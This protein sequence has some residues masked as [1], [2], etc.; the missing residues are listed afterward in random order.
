MNAALWSFGLYLLGVFALAILAGRFRRGKGF[1]GEYFLGSRDLGMW[2]FAL[3][4]AATAASGGSFM[5]FPSLV[6]THG[7]SLALWIAGYMTVP[8]VMMGLLGKRLNQF[9]RRAGAVTAPEVLGARYATPWVGGVATAVLLFFLFFY[10]VAQFK[11]GSSILA[12]LLRDVPAYQSAAVSLKEWVTPFEWLSDTSA[13]YLLSLLIFAVSVGVYTT[14]G[15]FRAVVW[16]DVMQGAVMAVGVVVLLCLTLAATGGLGAMTRT[17]ATMTPPE[18]GE[19][20]LTVEPAA[21]ERLTVPSGTW[22]SVPKQDGSQE[23]VRTGR[24]AVIDMG[25]RASEPVALLRVT[26]DEEASRI[27]SDATWTDL[28]V[29][30]TS[31]SPYAHGAGSPGAYIY[32][33]GPHPD[34][35]AGFLGL[36]MAFSFFVFWAFAG[37]GQP[38]AMVR[39]MAFRDSG[40]LKRAIVLVALYFS[41]IYFALVMVFVGARVLLPGR[42]L[43][44]DRIMPELATYLTQWAGVPWLAGLVVAA[45]FAAVMSSVD[46]FLL[47]LSSGVVRDI[48]QK[49]IHP[50]APE[51]RI[52]KL[53]YVSTA[54]IACAAMVVAIRPPDYLQKLIVF[55]SGGLAV[56]FLAPV[57]GSIYWRRMSGAGAIAGMLAGSGA[58]LWLYWAG[59]RATGKFQALEFLGLHSFIW[60]FLVSAV[61]S[62]VVSVWGPKPDPVRTRLFFDD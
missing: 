21:S 18:L 24:I 7:W 1:V 22:L 38:S 3:T 40:T 52:R 49:R 29:E 51:A 60:A 55:S 54:L 56:S 50:A 11:A 57:M 16:T 43:E 30:W 17:V 41:L 36:G 26:S 39:L 53:T 4:F 28:S 15:G 25:E 13:D 31:R 27:E 62:V 48:Y 61:A 42:E 14:Y 23:L 44:S 47:M 33:P 2:A 9:A 58:L 10:L 45:P 46:S 34:N 5:G 12:I 20:R 59:F 6:Y 8:L 19:A 35:E 32:P 37:A